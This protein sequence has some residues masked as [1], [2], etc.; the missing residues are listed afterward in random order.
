MLDD[1]QFSGMMSIRW[2]YLCN[3]F[4]SLFMFGVCVDL[5]HQP[6]FVT[7]IRICVMVGHTN[8]SDLFLFHTKCCVIFIQL[9]L[10]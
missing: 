6:L 2:I 3:E 4:A 7:L 5:G 8:I 9:A 1:I 10:T